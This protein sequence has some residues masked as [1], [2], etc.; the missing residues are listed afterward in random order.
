MVA[1]ASMKSQLKSSNSDLWSYDCTVKFGIIGTASHNILV[2]ETNL[3][4]IIFEGKIHILA[5]KSSKS[6]NENDYIA[7]LLINWN[8]LHGNLTS[9]WKN[10][11]RRR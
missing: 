6:P 4:R 10:A 2:I 11:R 3:H 5:T 7:D 9:E 8:T 1:Y